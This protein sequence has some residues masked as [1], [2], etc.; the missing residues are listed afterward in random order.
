MSDDVIVSWC[1]LIYQQIMPDGISQTLEIF[2]K[3]LVV[4]PPFLRAILDSP[5]KM[6][7]WLWQHVAKGFL[8]DAE[9][10]MYAFTRDQLI[11]YLTESS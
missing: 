1:D 9:A 6:Y 8:E 4:E 11:T 3:R 5:S 2:S 10:Q 7:D